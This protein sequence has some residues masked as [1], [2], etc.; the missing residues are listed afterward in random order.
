[1]VDYTT[2]STNDLIQAHLPIKFT[3]TSRPTTS[4]VA[5][6]RYQIYGKIN[7]RLGGTKTD[8]YG[9]LRDL[10]IDKVLQIIDNYWARGRGERTEPVIITDDDIAAL[11][12][13]AGTEPGSTGGHY[14]REVP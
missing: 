2:Y 6:F 8:T 14:S 4:Q 13:S 3:N 11:Q 7:Q 5:S 12:I 9:G 10:E 1:M